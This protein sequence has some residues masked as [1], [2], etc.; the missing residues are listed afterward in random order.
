M[1][2]Q[3]FSGEGLFRALEE[4]AVA[5]KAP[6]GITLVGM[7]KQSKEPEC[8]A[9]A[10]AGC[11]SWV[12]IP[13]RLI[14]KAVQLDDR[15]CNDH[16]H[17]V[18]RITLKEPADTEGRL[19]GKLLMASA[20]RW[21]G[22]ELPPSLAQMAVA[23]QQ[24]GGGGGGF[25]CDGPCQGLLRVCLEKTP[26]SSA[27]CVLLYQICYATCRLPGPIIFGAAAR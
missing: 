24:Q 1:S 21:G 16:A 22:A 4:Q 13:T 25:D 19:L 17:V 27:V 9:F 5:P 15:R 10:P 26:F 20:G 7:V 12:D 2:G 23:M 8:I 11:D 6:A 3:E 18:F 14:E